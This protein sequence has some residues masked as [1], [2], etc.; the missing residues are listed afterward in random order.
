[1]NQSGPGFFSCS[2]RDIPEAFLIRLASAVISS[3]VTPHLL[4]C[5]STSLDWGVAADN[6]NFDNAI[7]EFKIRNVVFTFNVLAHRVCG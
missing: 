6:L 5:C 1:M 4:G 3:A 2:A 7:R